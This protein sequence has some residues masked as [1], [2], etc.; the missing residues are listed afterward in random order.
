VP[1]SLPAAR[2]RD[3]GYLFWVGW[4]GHLTDSLFSTSD[5]QGPFR[6]ALL[7][8]SCD[9]I[10][11]QVAGFTGNPAFGPLGPVAGNFFTQVTNLTA[12]GGICSPGFPLAPK[13]AAAKSKAQ[14]GTTGGSGTPST[15]QV[16]ALPGLPPL[17]GIPS[18]PAPSTPSTPSTP[19]G[20]PPVPGL[21]K[22]LGGTG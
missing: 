21:P 2:R 22:L 3:E 13:S 16:P 18:V 5:S 10:R 9:T 15:P 1:N 8:F 4:V 19:G 20:L 17:P 6:R 7:G 11:Q 12:P 14:A